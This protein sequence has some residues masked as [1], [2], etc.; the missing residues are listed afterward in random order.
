MEKGPDMSTLVLGFNR[1]PLTAAA[2]ALSALVT[3]VSIASWDTSA[4]MNR[5]NIVP[6]PVQIE[7]TVDTTPW[8]RTLL[9]NR[10]GENE[11]LF[12]VLSELGRDTGTAGQ[13]VSAIQ[14]AEAMARVGVF[15]AER[16]DGRSAVV[17]AYKAGG[18]FTSVLLDGADSHAAPG[19]MR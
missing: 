7:G 19:G 10:L 3:F 13:G 12:H 18:V 17:K 16:T 8:H 5:D 15:D 2:C 11:L 14:M 4:E 1:K 9:D 6:Q